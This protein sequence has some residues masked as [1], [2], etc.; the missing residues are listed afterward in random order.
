MILET[1]VEK[2]IP[3]IDNANRITARNSALSAL[4]TVLMTVSKNNLKV[5]ATNLSLGIEMDIPVKSEKD[6]IVAIDGKILAEFLNTLPKSSKIKISVNETVMNVVT[7]RNRTTIKTHPYDDFPTL[8]AISGTDVLISKNEFIR[9]IKMTA[10]SA[11]LTDIKP[12]I[13]SVYV[14]SD[15]NNV[16]FAAT[17]SFRLA[18]K[19]EIM[20]KIADFSPIIIPY[21]NILEIARVIDGIQGDLK[22]VIGENQVS[23]SGNGIYLT[24]RIISGSFPDY[25]QIIPTSFT[26]DVIVLKQDILNVLKSANIFSDKFNQITFSISPSNKKME[27]LSKNSDIGEFSGQID[28]SLSGED[29]LISVNQ[30]YL[31]DCLNII[32]QD[33]ISIGLN[34]G[35]RPMVIKG[36][37]DTSFTYL[38]MPMNR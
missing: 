23:F 13:S 35:T 21:K 37:S 9:G 7:D 27:C 14:V 25:K 5:R 3:L 31:A 29:V 16:I 38:L 19:R 8:P 20:N 11:A 10:F 17:D 34:G 18:E 36:V 1:T 2:L 32:P 26:T 28:A 24:S 33:S 22:F 15:K 30:R 12:E 6:G 4:S